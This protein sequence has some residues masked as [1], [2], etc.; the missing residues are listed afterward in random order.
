M[1]FPEYEKQEKKANIKAQSL[2]VLRIYGT[3][4]QMVKVIDKDLLYSAGHRGKGKFP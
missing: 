2:Y 3:A 1:F 4:S